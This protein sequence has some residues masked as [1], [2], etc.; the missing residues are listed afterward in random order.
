MRRRL[1]G[2]KGREYGRR[3]AERRA[4][5]HSRPE[6]VHV[7]RRNPRGFLPASW[8]LFFL[9]IKTR[10]RKGRIGIFHLFVPHKTCCDLPPTG[11]H[12]KNWSVSAWAV[13]LLVLFTVSTYLNDIDA[14]AE[15]F[16]EPFTK[17]RGSVSPRGS[18][19]SWHCFL[20]S[21]LTD[22]IICYT[23]VIKWP[24]F[25]L[26]DTIMGTSVPPP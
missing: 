21:F 4:G 23:N 12:G 14:R 5:G 13:F 22:T 24:L 11:N 9:F 8:L 10:C 2:K 1:N 18:A 25:F 7:P 6:R 20:F 26:Y 3:N 19:D 16:R 15:V 17:L